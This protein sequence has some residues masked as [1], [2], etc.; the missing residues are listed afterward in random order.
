MTSFK[1]ILTGLALLALTVI[2]GGSA[3]AQVTGCPIGSTT[4]LGCYRVD[5]ITITVNAGVISAIGAAASSIQ[6]GVTTVSAGTNPFLLFDNNGTLGNESFASA[7]T[8][9]TTGAFG[10]VKVDGTTITISGG[11]ISS[12]GS[13]SAAFNA[14]TNGTNTTAAMVVGA[15]ASLNFTSSGTINASTLGGATFAAPGPIGGGTP[16]TGN[17]SSLTMTGNIGLSTH[18]LTGNFTIANVPIMS[19]LS[20]G[21]PATTLNLDGSNNIV[22]AVITAGSGITVTPSS[23]L[24]TISATGGVPGGIP[25]T[26]QFNN[27]GAFGGYAIGA[28]FTTSGGTFNLSGPT[29]GDLTGAWPTA[30][31]INSSVTPGPYTNA[32]ITID[33]Q[34]RVQAAAN[35]STSAGVTI[36][37]TPITG[38]TNTK[39]LYD[40]NGVIGEAPSI[41]SITCS[42]GMFVNAIP[43]NG[44]TTCGTPSGAALTITDGTHSVSSATT[45][46]FGNGFVV[47]G[48]A[49]SATTNLTVADTTKSGDYQ[50]A[51]G[52][53]A[54]ALNL[55]GAHTLTLPA[56]SSTIFAP[57]M[58]LNIVNSGSGNWT[59]TNSTGLAMTGLNSTTL[60]PGA[61]GSFV[62]NANG[63][64][65]DFFPGAQVATT[66]KLGAVM[67]DGTTITI[68]AGV[69]SS[70]GASG[71]NPTA[72][73]GSAAVNGSATT[74][75]RSD[76][77]P[78]VQKAT[79]AQFGIV[80]VD[81]AT[82]TESG[83]VIT[84]NGGAF[85]IPN[86]GSTGTTINK[87][88][89]VTGA[90]STAVI[91]ATTD[92]PS[93]TALGIVTGGAGTSGTATIQYSGIAT[94]IFD[95]AT[96][97]GHPVQ[98]STSTAG[99]C[100]DPGSITPSSGQIVGIVLGTIGSA[101]NAPVA[102]NIP[103]VNSNIDRTH[104][105]P[106][107]WI[108]GVTPNAGIITMSQP[109]TITAIIGRVETAVGSA[110][111]ISIFK[112]PSGTPCGSGT[113]LIS[114]SGTFNANGTAS[115]N[116]I[117]NVG[118]TALAAG[119]T[120]CT[121]S[122]GT[123]SG[124]PGNGDLTIYYTTP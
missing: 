51:A 28:A 121:T 60:Y 77:A 3:Q 86:A 89:K 112:A 102:L 114:G 25:G 81:G 68:S 103:P 78:A 45:L 48:S 65:I 49:G 63:T 120:V 14:I 10:C 118:T 61:S 31:L 124:N 46:T 42:A 107:G 44:V 104:S 87:L 110:A 99:D 22:K 80:E 34:G 2:G 30:T 92:S 12:V 113:N 97:A 94:C 95:G 8:A 7:C 116:Q 105:A 72:T 33:A 4:I 123:Y 15:G 111:T 32:N 74:F 5:G 117:L 75:M 101:G 23:G 93:S 106:I 119:D 54:N 109:S 59:V 108:A 69:I 100:H 66:S 82:I 35:G 27:G 17:F 84:V 16:G 52:D 19:G 37:S 70:V 73:A 98:L 1:K 79:G 38:G 21:T 36:N 26:L 24:I 6:V 56:A 62:A 39:T 91:T 29:G 88:A 64:G 41:Q 40:N 90:P 76:A 58:S 115:Q 85:F 67:V 71:A 20:N 57:G 53:M 96:V 43:S 83:G 9:A 11:V 13:G 50:V 18:S 55:T 47:S 122:T